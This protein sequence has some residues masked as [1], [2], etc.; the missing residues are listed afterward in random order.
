MA[1]DG[2]VPFSF[3]FFFQAKFCID[4]SGEVR[5][6]NDEG[7]HLQA[8]GFVVAAF[9]VFWRFIGLYGVSKCCFEAVLNDSPVIVIIF[10]IRARTAGIKF[11]KIPFIMPRDFASVTSIVNVFVAVTADGVQGLFEDFP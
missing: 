4:R 5:E 9:F 7:E 1:V 11:F 2:Y 8:V 6:L 10:N 3:G